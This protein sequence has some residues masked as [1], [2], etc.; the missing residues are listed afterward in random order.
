MVALRMNIV[1]SKREGILLS[2]LAAASF[3]GVFGQLS[4]LHNLL[5]NS[6]PFKMM[7]M[8]PAEFY[9]SIGEFG[10]Y[11]AAFASVIGLIV[12]IWLPRFLTSAI[13]VVIGPLAYWLVFE[14]GHLSQ[15]FTDE[16]MMELNFDGTT[17]TAVR[18]EFG[19]EILVLLVCGALIGSTIGIV[20]VKLAKVTPKKLA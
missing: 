12:S 10:F 3:I 18:H 19:F 5:V 6:Y 16:Q 4:L 15:R 11:I 20:A 17:G 1:N 2:V 9:A 14:I 13:P 8:P 7:D